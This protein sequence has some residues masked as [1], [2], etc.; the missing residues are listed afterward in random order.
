MAVDK[1]RRTGLF[2]GSFNPV[3]I[4]HMAIAAYF[5]AENYV[6]RFWF[7]VSPQ[8]PFKRRENLL[9]FHHR[10]ELLRRAIGDD[11][12][13]SVCEVEKHLPLPSYTVNTLRLLMEKYPQ[14]KF[15]LI[16]GADNVPTFPKWRECEWI[17]THCEVLVYPRVGAPLS[18]PPHDASH[19]HLFSNF[20]LAPAPVVEISSSMLRQWI[21]RGRSVR[22]L[23]PHEAWLYLDEMNFYKKR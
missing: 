18:W 17:A 4:G 8:N 2:F 3:H 7:V 10:V 19:A 23:M 1:K 11:N 5:L 12:R 9:P 22:H 6:D 15:F 21:I 13:M 14:E 16:M 20:R